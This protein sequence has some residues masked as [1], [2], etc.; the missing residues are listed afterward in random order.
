[1]NIFDFPI[2]SFDSCLFLLPI[3]GILSLFCAQAGASRVYAV[4]A[5]QLADI[6]RRVVEKNGFS[7]VIEVYKNENKNSTSVWPNKVV[8]RNFIEL[9]IPSLF[10]IV[11]TRY[12][13]GS[14]HEND[15]LI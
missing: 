11:V 1:M 2:T 7:D 8:A 5:S 6:T 9:S 4:E 12:L 13:G 3:L 14:I 15:L 10:F